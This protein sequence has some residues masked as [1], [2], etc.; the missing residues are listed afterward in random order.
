MPQSPQG[1]SFNLTYAF[2]REAKFSAYLLQRVC[3]PIWQTK[4]HA[5]NAGLSGRKR[6]QYLLHF[7][8]QQVLVRGI[9]GLR[10]TFILNERAELRFAIFTS[11]L[12][13]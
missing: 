5:Q 7:F 8:L 11:G 2:T 13:Q 1:F 6:G 9:A 10:H 12:L 4:T 3:L